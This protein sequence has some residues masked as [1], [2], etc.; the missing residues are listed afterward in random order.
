MMRRAADSV[1]PSLFDTLPERRPRPRPVPTDDVFFDR[2]RP[3]SR[4]KDDIVDDYLVPYLHKVSRLR[5]PIHLIDAFAGPGEFESGDRGSPLILTDAATEHATVSWHAYFANN[6]ERHHRR[7]DE[8]IQARGLTARAEAHLGPCGP[9]LRRL[10]AELHDRPDTVLVYADP[11]GLKGAEMANLSPLL[12][13][14]KRFS[15]ELL[16]NLS[17]P[18][19]AR[20]ANR[21]AA[22][23]ERL[24]IVLG[25]TWWRAVRRS[26]GSLHAYAAGYLEQLR[27]FGFDYVGACP[28]CDGGT[29]K[30][31]LVFCSRHPDSARLMNDIMLNAVDRHAPGSRGCAD[32]YA[33]IEEVVLVGVASAPGITRDQLWLQLLR[34]HFAQFKAKEFRAAVKQ[35]AVAGRLRFESPTDQLNDGARLWPG[36]ARA[37]R[38]AG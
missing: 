3:W 22:D 20:L 27:S 34:T 19:I 18:T 24:D 15:T 12:S 2:K 6:E 14:S 26:G 5:V 16:L 35:L 10:G 4:I 36:P 7:V 31:H 33:G 28:V 32:L 23:A 11:F 38:A 25:G 1:Q 29:V 37:R 30:Y 9:L 17:T 21:Y 8:L 13:R